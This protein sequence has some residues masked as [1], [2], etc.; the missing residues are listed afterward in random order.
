MELYECIHN[1]DTKHFRISDHK[2]QDLYTGY[3]SY[4]EFLNIRDSLGITRDVFQEYYKNRDHIR[5]NI[6]IRETYD[7]GFIVIVKQAS[8]YDWFDRIAFYIHPQIFLIVQIKDEDDSTRRIYEEILEQL[9]EPVSIGKFIYS[10]FEQ[11]LRDDNQLMDTIRKRITT[12]EESMLSSGVNQSMNRQIFS[13]KKELLMLRDYYE[14]LSEIGQELEENENDIL[15]EEEIKYIRIFNGKIARLEKSANSLVELTIQ[16]RE[17]YEAT[18]DI[19]LNHI[20]YVFTVI[21]AIFLP[22]TLIAGWYGMNFEHMPELRW[23]YG[24]LYVIILAICVVVIW[25]GFFRKKK[26]M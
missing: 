7:V 3:L 25:I 17:V 9:K 5:C 11:L 26:F 15:K 12:L 1:T 23:K 16:L 8:L 4:D 2:L 13:F 18:L 6:E 19:S 22:L 24:Y 21:T 20:T 14:Q 10:Y